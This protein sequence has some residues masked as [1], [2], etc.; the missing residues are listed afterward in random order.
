M[1]RP[2]VFQQV[3]ASGTV[4]H[5]AEML[6]LHVA[7]RLVGAKYRHDFTSRPQTLEQPRLQVIGRAR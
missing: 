4:M 7:L 1:S 3:V 5:G 2:W 6:L